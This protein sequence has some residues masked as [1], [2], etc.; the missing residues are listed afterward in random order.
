MR[1]KDFFF[2]SL[3]YNFQFIL[4]FDT[5]MVI[6]NYNHEKN[7]HVIDFVFTR[8]HAQILKYRKTPRKRVHHF[9]V[10]L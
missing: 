2:K 4:K 6:L 1:K 10:D 8:T 9:Q 3:R 7:D 5:K